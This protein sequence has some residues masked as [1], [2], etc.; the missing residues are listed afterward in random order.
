MNAT[1]AQPERSGEREQAPPSGRVDEQDAL[2]GEP[3]ALASEPFGP[4]AARR[5]VKD[6]GRALILYVHG[7]REQA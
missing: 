4:L 1:P 7:E 3:D 2:A 6:D 5:L